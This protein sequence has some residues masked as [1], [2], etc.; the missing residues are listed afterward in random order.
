MTFATHRERQFMEYLHGKGWVKGTALPPSR[1]AISL[2]ERGWIEQQAQG[3][4]NEIF[5]RMTDIGL[6][7]L[8]APV[9]AGRPSQG[10]MSKHN[11]KWTPEEDQRLLALK[12][13]GAP[14]A[15]IAEKLGRTQASVDTRT[16]KLKNQVKGK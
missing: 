15:I 1:L 2:Q 8:R 4:R 7:A 11:T 6:K 5:Y 10:E 3:P 13:A 16:A 12:A 9:P 14:L